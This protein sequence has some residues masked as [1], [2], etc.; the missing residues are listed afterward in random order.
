MSE[1]LRKVCRAL[2]YFEHVLIFASVVS[3]CASLVGVL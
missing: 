2:N 1:K 3:A